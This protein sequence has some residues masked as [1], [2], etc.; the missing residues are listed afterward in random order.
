MLNKIRKMTIIMAAVCVLGLFILMIIQ[1]IL[2]YSFGYSSFFVEETGRYLLIWSVLAG[3]AVNTFDNE[4]L[5]VD[6]LVKFLNTRVRYLWLLFIETV[7]LLLFTILVYGGIKTVVFLQDQNSAGLQ[8]PLSIPYIA[9]PLFFSISCVFVI[10]R[11]RRIWGKA[12]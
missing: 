12:L 9:I 4:H 3:S 2:R 8:L 10:D 1:V 6:F 5:R 7:S 11:I